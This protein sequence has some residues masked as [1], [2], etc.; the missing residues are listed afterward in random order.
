MRAVVRDEYGPP[1]VLRL[2]EVEEPVPKDGEVLVEVHAASVNAAD[3]HILRPDPFF[4]R[5][6][7]FGVFKPRLRILG[8]DVAGRVES[9]GRDVTQLKAGD[10]VYGELLNTM[11]AFAEYV[12]APEKALAVKPANLT[13][14]EAAAVPMAALTA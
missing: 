7:G 3:W 1:S 4:V 6:M 5:F 10:E 8:G 2:D 11:G 14:E 9:V 12:S 13:F